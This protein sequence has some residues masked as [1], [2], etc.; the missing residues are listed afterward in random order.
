MKVLHMSVIDDS[1]KN[2][3]TAV[4]E[5]KAALQSEQIITPAGESVTNQKREL[6]TAELLELSSIRL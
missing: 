3:E 2:L 4:A 5:L 6:T 1:I